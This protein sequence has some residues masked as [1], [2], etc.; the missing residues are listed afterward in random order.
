MSRFYNIQGSLPN[1][2]QF[3]KSKEQ[4]ENELNDI[5]NNYNEYYSEMKKNNEKEEPTEKKESLEKTGNIEE[6][7]GLENKEIKG[8][9]GKINNNKNKELLLKIIND[10][11]KKNLENLEKR[12]STETKTLNGINISVKKIKGK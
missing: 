7:K 4:I 9:E 10:R 8:E 11:I 5:E 1:I 6:K 12:N 2:N 3:C